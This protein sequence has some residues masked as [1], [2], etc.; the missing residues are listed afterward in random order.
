MH[1]RTLTILSFNQKE[2]STGVAVTG[3]E[4]GNGGL[5]KG[6][7]NARSNRHLQ[8]EPCLLGSEI[9]QVDCY[10]PSTKQFVHISGSSRL[11]KD[12]HDGVTTSGTSTLMQEGANF[13][14]GE[15]SLIFPDLVNVQYEQDPEAPIPTT[16]IFPKVKAVYYDVQSGTQLVGNGAGAY[17]GHIDTNSY[18]TYNSLNFGPSGT[19]KS[20]QI[21]YSKGDNGGKLEL[22]IGGPTGTLIGEYSPAKTGNWYAFTD[23][24]SDSC[25]KRCFGSNEYRLVRA[26]SMS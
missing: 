24:G 17:I 16:E 19:T 6:N 15:G 2:S 14:D 1:K 13:D 21:R 26:F 25:W 12:F 4:S 22:R 18:L 8:T 9:E 23:S 5:R 3:S 7:Q 11:L 10:D 20:V